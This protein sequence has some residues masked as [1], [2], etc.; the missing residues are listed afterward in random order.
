L[1]GLVPGI[2]SLGVTIFDVPSGNVRKWLMIFSAAI[3]IAG[4]ILLIAFREFI[5]DLNPDPRS[6]I[7]L[8]VPA[9]IMAIV[10]DRIKQKDRAQRHQQMLAA[11]RKKVIPE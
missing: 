2:S 11:S 9:I 4:P 1:L 3:L 8:C 10:S 6:I 7:L 5:I